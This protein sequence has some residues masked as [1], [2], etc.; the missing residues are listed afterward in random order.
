[1]NPVLFVTDYVRWHY[2]AALFDML[3]VWGNLLWFIIHTSSFFDLFKTL[4]S[5]W[6]R[7]HEEKPPKGTFDPSYYVGSL[8]VNALMRVVGLVVRLFLITIALVLFSITFAVGVF[9]MLFWLIA[10]VAIFIIFLNGLAL[11]SF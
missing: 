8:T 3:R 5:P 11:I 7:M 10:P 6:K 1:M 9:F 2:G 4:L